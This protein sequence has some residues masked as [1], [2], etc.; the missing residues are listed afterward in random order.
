[1]SYLLGIVTGL[2]ISVIIRICVWYCE[3]SAVDDPDEYWEDLH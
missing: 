2:L 1:M 3:A